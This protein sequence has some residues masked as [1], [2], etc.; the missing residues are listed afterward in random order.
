MSSLLLPVFIDQTLQRAFEQV[1]SLDVKCE[2]GTF[3]LSDKH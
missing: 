3:R 2:G 1:V